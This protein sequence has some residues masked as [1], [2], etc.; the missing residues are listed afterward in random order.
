MDSVRRQPS[1]RH[2]LG[3]Y[4]P[5]DAGLEGRDHVTPDDVRAMFLPPIHF[6][7]VESLAVYQNAPKVENISRDREGF[8]AGRRIDSAT[9]V[10]Q[11]SE[12]YELPAVT[13]QW[14]DLRLGKLCEHRVSP[15]AFDAAPNPN[16]R[17]E[18]APPP[19]RG[20]RGGGIL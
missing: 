17:P 16:Y 1:R 20:F 19:I 10:V 12:Q 8:I 4:R 7:E 2:Q 11:K 18:I 5:H 3:T 6:A 15:V 13:V 9:Y 14:W